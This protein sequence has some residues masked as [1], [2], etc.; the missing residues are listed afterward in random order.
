MNCVYL[1]DLRIRKF[2][3]DFFFY[4]KDTKTQSKLSNCVLISWCPCVF[5]I[6]FPILR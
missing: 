5:S 3:Y 2:L 4:H 6:R 1:P